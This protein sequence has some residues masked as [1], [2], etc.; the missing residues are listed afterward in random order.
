[1]IIIK[2][3]SLTCNVLFCAKSLDRNHG[4]VHTWF[5]SYY[6]I[7]HCDGVGGWGE[8]SA[9]LQAVQTQMQIRVQNQ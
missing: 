4:D 9:E 7:E 5:H 6:L 3:D 2:K 1:M 8:N